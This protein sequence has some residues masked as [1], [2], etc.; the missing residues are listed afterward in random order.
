MTFAKWL[1]THAGTLLT[2]FCIGVTVCALYLHGLI[3]GYRIAAEQDLRP[4]GCFQP[5]DT[6][7]VRQT[8]WYYVPVDD[9]RAETYSGIHPN[10]L[11][12]TEPR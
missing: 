11:S 1:G 9:P 8:R 6:I 5:H 7:Y 2:L 4:I 10:L 12:T 3:Q